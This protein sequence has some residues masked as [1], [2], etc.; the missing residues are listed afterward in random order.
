MAR[1]LKKNKEE[2]EKKEEKK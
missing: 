2:V 1:A